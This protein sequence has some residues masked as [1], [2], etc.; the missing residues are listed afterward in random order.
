MRLSWRFATFPSLTGKKLNEEL[1]RAIIVEP[2]QIPPD[3]ITMRS[4]AV[5]L[6]VKT[7]EEMHC[8]LVFPDDSNPGQE[9][10]SVLAPI[11]TGMLG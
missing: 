6:D 4:T 11:G 1:Y 5:L 8:T 3:V 9:K 10:I 7:G 2:Q